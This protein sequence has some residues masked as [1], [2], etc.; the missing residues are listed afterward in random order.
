MGRNPGGERDTLD[1][2]AEPRRG[3]ALECDEEGRDDFR[4]SASRTCVSGANGTLSE[5]ETAAR[6]GVN[7]R[8]DGAFVV[9]VY[10]AC[11]FAFAQR[12]RTSSGPA[13]HFGVRR[14]P[15]APYRCG[16]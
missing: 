8:E 5:R 1:M 16:A 9:R 12:F 11:G 13:A 3:R 14:C 4:S 10:A 6:M 7:V 15:L 2:I